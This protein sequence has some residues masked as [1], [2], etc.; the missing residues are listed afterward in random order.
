MASQTFAIITQ[1]EEPKMNKK[2]SLVDIVYIIVVVFVF[3]V[4]ILFGAKVLNSFN[5]EVATITGIPAEAI[6]ANTK[7]EGHYG[8]VMDNMTMFLLIGFGISALVM[9][10]MV[11]IHPAF[12]FIYFIMLI[13]VIVIS[14]V[15]SNVYG[16]IAESSQLTGIADTMFMTGKILQF[17]P[18]IIGVFGTILSIIMYQ[19]YRNDN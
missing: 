14:A 6:S 16:E 13:V 9:A 7:L 2:G 5:T 17:L 3:G 15:M 11:R 4:V 8:G 1:K 18:I 12:F 19:G 10:S